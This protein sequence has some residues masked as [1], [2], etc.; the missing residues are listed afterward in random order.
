MLVPLAVEG[1]Y[2]ANWQ[3]GCSSYA[4]AVQQATQ[5]AQYGQLAGA[6]FSSE[7]SSVE[8][9]RSAAKYAQQL[10]DLVADLRL[11][12]ASPDL[13][14]LLAEPGDFGVRG[15]E[16]TI[17]AVRNAAAGTAF[18]VAVS[19]EG[20]HHAGDNVHL[21]STSQR[22]LAWRFAAEWRLLQ[23]RVEDQ[24]WTA[25]RVMEPLS[26]AEMNALRD[27][28]EPWFLASY[29]GGNSAA[30]GSYASHAA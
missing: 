13:P 12:L 23:A 17:H 18:C 19:S 15:Q 26:I 24:G 6:L 30:P 4:Y 25:E 8:D 1:T 3:R 16:H 10:K 27:A 14:F 28:F 5:A 21:D 2:P 7:G 29:H 20:F 11:D 9:A 22:L